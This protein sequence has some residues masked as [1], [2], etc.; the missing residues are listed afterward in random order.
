MREVAWNTPLQYTPLEYLESCTGG[1]NDVRSYMQVPFDYDLRKDTIAFETEHELTNFSQNSLELF[2]LDGHALNWG[3]LVNE[4]Y[5]LRYDSAHDR[6]EK[7]I[8]F[9]QTSGFHVW[10]L[11][12]SADELKMSVDGGI[13]VSVRLSSPLLYPQP[14]PLTIFGVITDANTYYSSWPLIAKKKYFR[15]W[16]NNELIYDLFPALDTTDRPCMFNRANGQFLYNMGEVEFIC[17]P[18]IET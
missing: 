13:A 12:C 6:I 5:V 4:G 3:F 2:S 7:T 17:G 15:V 9:S 1:Q 10:R 8:N 14:W 18:V 11:E 16:K